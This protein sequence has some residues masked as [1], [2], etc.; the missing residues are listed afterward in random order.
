ML[1]TS[2]G[3]TYELSGPDQAPVFTLIHGLGVK[4]EL[5]HDHVEVLSRRYRV[6]IYDLYG[7]GQSSRSPDTLSLAVFSQQLREL[8]DE[9]D[10]EHSVIAGFS[11]GGMINRRFAMDYPSRVSALIVLN[12]P[13][14]R[15]PDEQKL[16]EERVSRTVQG[17]P[18]ATIETSLERWF[19]EDF[20]ASR[21]D[22]V[23]EIRT[24]V[25]ANDPVIYT[26]CRQVL[27]RGVL[28]LVHPEPPITAPTLVIT[29]E[30]D[31]GSTPNMARAIAADIPGA[32]TV[33]VPQLQHLGLTEK[34][35]LF[36]EPILR[37]LDTIPG[38]G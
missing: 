34:P 21:A 11:L 33:I 23:S 17:G 22:V 28:E 16:V 18:E 4:R 7:H 26:Q 8:L 13:H 14:E 31:S 6:L 5:W 27:A 20:R 2:S 35:V 15:E 3:T 12:S 32:Q 36:L 25:L 1:K 29:C 24:W 9:L 19:T 37:F 38:L 30:N 10:I